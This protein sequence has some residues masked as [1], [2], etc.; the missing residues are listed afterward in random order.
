MLEKGIL[1]WQVAKELNITDSNFSR[2]LR[3]E[4]HLHEKNRIFKIIDKLSKGEI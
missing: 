3:E 4:L 1:Y 2:M